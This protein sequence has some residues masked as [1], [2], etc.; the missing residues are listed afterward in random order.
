MLIKIKA[1]FK[2]TIKIFQVREEWTQKQFDLLP[3]PLMFFSSF[4]NSK[5]QSK[6]NYAAEGCKNNFLFFLIIFFMVR[7]QDFMYDNH[8]MI[9]R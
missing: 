1:F 2:N 3:M 7:F 5:S 9:I 8:I 4:F 6:D